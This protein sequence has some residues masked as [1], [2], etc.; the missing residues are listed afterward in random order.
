MPAQGTDLRPPRTSASDQQ[1]RQYETQSKAQ[2]S[3]FFHLHLTHLESCPRRL[4]PLF[5]RCCEGTWNHALHRFIPLICQR[6]NRRSEIMKSDQSAVD[7]H[8]K[9]GRMSA[10]VRDL[11]GFHSRPVPAMSQVQPCRR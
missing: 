5:E 8:T 11:F 7:H 6:K 9:N 3:A 2:S 10:K 4:K 1:S